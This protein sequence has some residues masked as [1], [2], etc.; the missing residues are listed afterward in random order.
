LPNQRKGEQKDRSRKG[1]KGGQNKRTEEVR[2]GLQLDSID[3]D[4]LS[5][6]MS[7]IKLLSGRK[8]Q[9]VVWEYFV[10]EDHHHKSRYTVPNDKEEYAVFT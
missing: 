9:S 5:S 7:L 6:K 4:R 1:P 2:I 10:N 3:C 8:R